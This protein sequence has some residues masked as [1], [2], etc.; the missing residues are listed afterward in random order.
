MLPEL[1]ARHQVIL[2]AVADPRIGDMAAGRSDAA[3]VYDAAAAERTSNDRRTIASRL[4]LHG[5]GSSTPH[6]GNWPP[7]W[8]TATWR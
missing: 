7:P 8:P 5:V 3:E 2:A 4:R 6:R 1:S